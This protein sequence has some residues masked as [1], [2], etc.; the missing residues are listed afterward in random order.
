MTGFTQYLESINILWCELLN[1]LSHIC[2]GIERTTGID[3]V[4]LYFL[5]REPVITLAADVFK[6]QP[7]VTAD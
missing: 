3:M 6:L 1:E 7:L 2:Q 5:P 4:N